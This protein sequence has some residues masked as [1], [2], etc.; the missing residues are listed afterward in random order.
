VKSIRRRDFLQGSALA[1]GAA[2]TGVRVSA[3]APDTYP[4][5]LTGLRGAHPGSFEV[6]H[7]LA[8]EGKRWPRPARSVDADYDLV[9]VGAGISG[10]AAAHFYRQR[11]GGDARI[12]VLDNHDDIGGHARRNEFTVARHLL[13]GYAGS[14]TLEN[15]G[16]YSLAARTLLRELGV[17]TKR[18]ERYYDADFDQRHAL[19][20]GVLVNGALYPNAFAYA[21]V[22]VADA[23]AAIATYPLSAQARRALAAMTAREVRL[24]ADAARLAREAEA[25]PTEAFLRSAFDMPDDGLAFLRDLSRPLWGSGLDTLS[26]AESVDEHVLGEPLATATAAARAADSTHIEARDESEPYICH[27]PDGNASVARLLARTLVP[28]FL[29]GTTM[30]DVVLAHAHYG[31]LDAPA[32]RV[33]IRLRSTA[34]AVANAAGGVDVTYVRDGRAERVRAADCV[35][36]CWN[37]VIPYLLDELRDA[38]RAALAYP[39]KVPF[40]IVN[41]ALR[42]WRALARSGFASFYAPGAF[43]TQGGLDFPVSMGGYR[44][45]ER[46]DAPAVL[47]FWHAPAEGPVGSDP[48]AQFRAGRER[49]YTR[50]FAEFERAI[51]EQLDTAWGSHGLDVARDVA[52]ITVNRWPHGY[53]YEYMDLWDDRA[54]SR[55]AGPHVIAR[56]QIGRIAIANSDSEQYAYVNGAIDAA[57]RAVRELT[58]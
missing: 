53:A 28:A 55:G 22:P 31:A 3:A 9:V 6:A 58:T 27:F 25:T 7:A 44:F 4:P 56:Q 51:L 13:I 43:L 11:I 16:R 18:F 48:K 30:E 38:Q 40:A 19:R 20:D 26:V 23:Q 1:I 35:L 33:R 41:V 45:T 52:A 46:P 15:P 47:Q 49:L 50:S 34:V 12:L 37:N 57:D 2:L 29:P 24:T 8:R 32:N 36:A 21:G 54:W 5:A 14:Q 10:L 17:E 42:D 39:E